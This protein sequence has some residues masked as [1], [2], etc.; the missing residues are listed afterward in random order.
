M[1]FHLFDYKNLTSCIVLTPTL[2]CLHG[3][4]IIEAVLGGKQGSIAIDDIMVY[5]SESD[6][7]PAEKECTFQSSLCGLLPEPSTTETWARMTGMSKPASS[8]GPTADHTLGTDQGVHVMFQLQSASYKL[9]P[10]QPL[11]SEFHFRYNI[12]FQ[13]ND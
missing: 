6:S 8:S 5:R 10:S 3:Q 11:V 7:C 9:E 4:F 2:L 12:S 13:S 1:L